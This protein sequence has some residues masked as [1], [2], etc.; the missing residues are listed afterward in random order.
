MHRNFERVGLTVQTAPLRCADQLK[1]DILGDFEFELS[2][3]YLLYRNKNE[4]NGAFGQSTDEKAPLNRRALRRGFRH[5]FK[6]QAGP[7][8]NLSALPMETAGL[9]E[10]TAITTA[11]P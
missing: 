9:W 3:P 4:V 2:P 5:P 6:Q 11:A 10:P 8:R 7:R 1:E